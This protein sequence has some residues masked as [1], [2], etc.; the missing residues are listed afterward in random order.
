MSWAGWTERFA[1]GE[2][3]LGLRRTAMVVWAMWMTWECFTRGLAYAYSL[4]K[5][6]AAIMAAATVVG[7]LQLPITALAGIVC[8]DY[9]RDKQRPSG[10]VQPPK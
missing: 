6:S 4:G 10:D 2:R 1:A 5:D 9:F 7:A 3:R 8:R